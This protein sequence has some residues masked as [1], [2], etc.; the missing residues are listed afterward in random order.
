[1]ALWKTKGLQRLWRLRSLRRYLKG[2]STKYYGVFAED[3]GGTLSELRR[4]L[5]EALKINSY[6][7]KVFPAQYLQVRWSLFF[8]S[9]AFSALARSS[10]NVCANERLKHC[11][12]QHPSLGSQKRSADLYAVR[13]PHRGAN[14]DK[15]KKTPNK[16][17]NKKGP[18]T[19]CKN[20][21]R[22]SRQLMCQWIK[23]DLAKKQK[24]TNQTS[25][26]DRSEGV[27]NNPISS[28]E[29][30]DPPS[31]DPGD[32]TEKPYGHEASSLAWSSHALNWEAT[33]RQAPCRGKQPRNN[34]GEKMS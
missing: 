6:K 29:T 25:Q 19:P 26:Q 8:P 5:F 28:A 15:T 9:S 1:M 30:Q 24:P 27:G 12:N 32:R 10:H 16:T 33:Q 23:E 21:L 11:M 13:N 3:F 4:I 2:A 22:R 20:E 17:Q 18:V 34:G 14:E 7:F 31:Q